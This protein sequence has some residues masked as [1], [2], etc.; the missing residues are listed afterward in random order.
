MKLFEVRI[1]L[2][3]V[4]ITFVDTDLDGCLSSASQTA[5]ICL[6]LGM[7]VYKDFTSSVTSKLSFGM[8]LIFN[9]VKRV[10]VSRT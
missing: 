1:R 2:R 3:N 6:L 4:I 7:L 8:F 5:L 9:F 10:L